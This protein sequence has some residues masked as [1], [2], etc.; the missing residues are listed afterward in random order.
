MKAGGMM[1]GAAH[2]GMVKQALMKKVKPSALLKLATGMKG[3]M[4]MG[5][6]IGKP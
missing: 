6:G 2:T 5:R 4:K 3:G 1:T